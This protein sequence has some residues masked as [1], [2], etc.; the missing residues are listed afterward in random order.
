MPAAVASARSQ[1]AR[2][3]ALTACGP[4]AFLLDLELEQA[5]PDFAPGAFA[6]LSP[7][8]GGGPVIARPFSVYDRLDERRLRFLI[9]VL[10]RGTRHLCALVPG[11]AVQI[12]VPLGN[13]FEVAPAGEPVVMVAGGVGSAP[14]LMYAQRRIAA[15]AAADTH[16]LF[17]A[18][19]ADRLYDQDAFAALD[20]PM[21]TATDDGSSGYHGN[22]VQL[23]TDL[24]ERAQLPA[25]ARFC[26]CGPEGLLHA[27]ATFARARGLRAELSLE[28]Y[29][30]CGFGV[31]NA[32]P[33][34]TEPSGPLGH[35]P[36]ARTCVDGPV[37]ALSSIR[38]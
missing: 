15:G 11:D 17:G 31:C 19:S 14:F 13:G 16:F 25:E 10:G 3:D 4:D 35:W 30:G 22:L 12:T 9:Q 18:R 32:C 23:L 21:H 33:I 6:M 24:L 28:T 5:P 34:P 2:L 26:A 20:M 36:W 37:F 7:G 1:L 29:M 38:F 27:F 8:H